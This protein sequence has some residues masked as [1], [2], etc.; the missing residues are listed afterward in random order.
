[1]VSDNYKIWTISNRFY[2]LH[3]TPKSFNQS[4]V[5]IIWQ[6][7]K[8]TACIPFEGREV[9]DKVF[10]ASCVKPHE[11]KRW[12]S[13]WKNLHAPC[14]PNPFHSSI[15][16]KCRRK[17]E[18]MAKRHS[19]RKSLLS[20][21]GAKIPFYM[22]CFLRKPLKVFRKIS[23]LISVPNDRNWRFLAENEVKF[24]WHWWRTFHWLVMV[25]MLTVT[26]GVGLTIDDVWLKERF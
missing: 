5:K 24:S 21:Y 11:H 15:Q 7:V 23:S 10:L 4:T 2:R 9:R 22:R 19:L 18:N 13:L 20:I 16:G 14:P 3:H 25:N 17:N 6:L 26:P 1:M 12:V 8:C